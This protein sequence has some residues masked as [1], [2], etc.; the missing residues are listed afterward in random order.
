MAIYLK[1][2]ACS[3]AIA[4]YDLKENHHNI[5]FEVLRKASNALPS[6]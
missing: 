6:L 4:C 1:T 5:T 2:A 3:I